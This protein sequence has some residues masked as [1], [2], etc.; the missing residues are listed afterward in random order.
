MGLGWA[1][2]CSGSLSDVNG[3]GGHVMMEGGARYRSGSLS[4]VNEG[5][6]A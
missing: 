1:G 4:D 5:H 2:Y 6:F 3:A